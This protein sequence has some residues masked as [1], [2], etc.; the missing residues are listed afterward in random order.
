MISASFDTSRFMRDMKNVLEYSVGFLD[1][2]QRGKSEMITKLGAIVI[3]SLK[4]FIDS[5]ARANPAALHHV[6]EW[7]KVGSPEAR[8]FDID[9]S[10]TGMGLSVNSTF[11]QSQ[12]VKK[13]SGVPFYDKATIME[14]GI[15]VTIRPKKSSVLVFEADGKTIFTSNEVSVK[16]PGGEETVGSYKD[17]FESFFRNYFSQAFLNKSGLLGYL[18][19]ASIFKANL[20]RGKN[21]GRGAGVATGYKWITNLDEVA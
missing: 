1:G 8:L 21:L 10:V 4:E 14:N 3:E 11:R 17:T 5:N 19:D 6:Y 18:S 15:P 20:R 16:N 12:S 2:A 9:Y 13:N 7:Y